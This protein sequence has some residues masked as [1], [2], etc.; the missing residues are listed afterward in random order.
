MHILITLRRLR[1]ATLANMPI[2]RST[3]IKGDLVISNQ[4]CKGLNR[5]SNV[6]SVKLIY[7]AGKLL[8]PEL[9]DATAS[10]MAIEGLP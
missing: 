2:K 9:Y 6:A 4:I 5:H 7:G 1:G 8:L 10:T 3:A